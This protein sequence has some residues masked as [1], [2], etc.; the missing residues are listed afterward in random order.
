MK[1]DKRKQTSQN[2]EKMGLNLRII[3]KQKDIHVS[4][5]GG[6]TRLQRTLIKE[7]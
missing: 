7:Y 4:Q 5:N 1:K 2:G 3:K 6:R